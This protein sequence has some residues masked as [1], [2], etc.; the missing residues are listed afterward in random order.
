MLLDE[1]ESEVKERVCNL[2]VCAGSTSL[3]RNILRN[4]TGLVMGYICADLGALYGF[5][6]VAVASTRGIERK[7]KE[8]HAR[9]ESIALWIRLLQLLGM[10][11]VRMAQR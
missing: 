2:K 6:D 8:S 7:K 1:V 11:S 9:S 4:G 3:T 10:E 5:N